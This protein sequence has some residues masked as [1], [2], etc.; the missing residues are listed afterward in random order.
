[1][2]IETEH[3]LQI[4]TSPIDLAR[5]SSWLLGTAMSAVVGSIYFIG[6]GRALDYDGSVTVGS[7]V[8]NGSL[9]D[10]FRTAYAFN[11]HP[12]FSFFEHLLWDA[13]GHSEV[14]LRVIPI[15]CAAATVGVVATWAARRWGPTA[16]PIGGSV[17]A[18]NP[19]FADLGRSVRGYSLMLL[20]CTIAT[21]VFVDSHR[22]QGAMTTRQSVIYAVSLGIAIGTQFYAVPVLAAHVA[23]LLAQHR[24]D[25]RWRRRVEV[26]IAIGALP[27]AA[28]L[29]PLFDATRSRRGAFQPGFPIEA[30]RGILGQQY[31]AVAILAVLTIYALCLPA[32][33]R[34]L[35]PAA[36]VIVIALLTVWVVL[37][38]LDLYPRFLIWIVPAVA[39]ATASTVARRPLLTPI[40]A[41]AIL[42]MVLSQSAS[43][44]TDPIA[45]RQAAE[46]VERAR[47][48]GKTPCAAGY[49]T[50]VILGYTRRVRS[51]FNAS[52]LAGCDTMFADL[53]TSGAQIREL[54]CHFE[55]EDLLPGLTKIVVFS[56]P[57]P[58]GSTIRCST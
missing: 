3:E 20:G 18:A 22:T 11:N 23:T 5:R 44:T 7:F 28:M 32:V 49:S 46:I 40:A 2:V 34:P 51:V 35:Q 48:N 58:T 12:Y 6:S 42:A 16:G 47:A 19:M 17:L 57:A 50:E 24:L 13:G 54:G 25:T 4:E 55:H 1:V 33:R 15:V 52:Q 8:R 10:V 26:V 9:L 38:P 53:D 43:W 45:S 30:V 56:T 36:A 41:V 29:R 39:I 14:W 21:V 37:H 27:Y 31:L